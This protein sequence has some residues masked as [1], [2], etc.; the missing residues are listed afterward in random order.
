MEMANRM[1]GERWYQSQALWW[2]AIGYTGLITAMCWVWLPRV[3]CIADP[4]LGSWAD[5][6]AAV[7]TIGAAFS[8]VWLAMRGEAAR[9]RE[10][11][12]RASLAAVHLVQRMREMAGSVHMPTQYS[13]GPSPTASARF[14]VFQQAVVEAHKACESICQILTDQR[15]MEL[16]DLPDRAAHKMAKAKSVAAMVVA[17][18]ETVLEI[19]DSFIELADQYELWVGAN[20]QALLEIWKLLVEAHT[21]VQRVVD[22]ALA[23]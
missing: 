2:L 21:T 1:M 22:E 4:A 11:S 20:T 15:L 12:F 7:G 23:G 9:A 17:R 16:V 19:R 10:R 6:F 8:A 13:A 18:A 14:Q 5:W 3:R